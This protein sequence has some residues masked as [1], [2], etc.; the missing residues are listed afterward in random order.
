MSELEV[1][2]E[3]ARDKATIQGF[4]DRAKEAEEKIP[5]I[6]KNGAG[7]TPYDDMVLY[8]IIAKPKLTEEEMAGVD[9]KVLDMLFEGDKE[10][11][12]TDQKLVIVAKGDGCK[13]DIKPGDRVAIRG[14]AFRITTPKGTFF[15]VREY[16]V[17][18]KYEEVV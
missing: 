14:H 11:D 9:T 5:E 3:P 15:T 10:G 18:G 1:Y 6:L 2:Q 16:D 17:I 7:F 8:M 12:L 13:K 4:L